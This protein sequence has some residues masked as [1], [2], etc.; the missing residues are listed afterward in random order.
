MYYVLYIANSPRGVEISY[1]ILCILCRE[2]REKMSKRVSAIPKEKRKIMA[3]KMLK[4][5]LKKYGSLAPP[6][7]NRTSTWK[8]GW[9]EFGDRKYF[10]RS[11]WEANYGRYLEILKKNGQIK[12]WEHEPKTFWFENIKRGSVTYL[13]DFKVTNLDDTHYWVEVKGWMDARSKTKIKR[14]TKYFPQEKLVVIAA[15]EYNSLKKKVQR[16][17]PGWEV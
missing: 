9:R 5:K 6:N 2:V 7:V 11:R 14:F 16:I 8:Q 12:E 10:Y 13:P 3:V 17:I 4:T 1:A 15:K